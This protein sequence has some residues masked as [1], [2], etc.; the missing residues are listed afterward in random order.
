MAVS[1]A[2]CRAVY[3]PIDCSTEARVE[4][5]MWCIT[6][7]EKRTKSKRYTL[8]HHLSVLGMWCHQNGILF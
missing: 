6:Q 8:A 5:N 4:K 2:C 7:V 3:L 1:A